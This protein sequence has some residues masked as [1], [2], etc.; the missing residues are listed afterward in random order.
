MELKDC[1]KADLLWV[2]DRATKCS[3]G[4]IG[5][6]IEQALCDLECKK[7]YDRIEKTKELLETSFKARQEYC[8]LLKPYEGEPILDVPLE[9][10]KKADSALKRSREADKKYCKLMGI[11]GFKH[12]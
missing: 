6:W 3:L 4:D 10:L 11:K 5:Y 1:T 12:T 9:V 8:D 2:I 7:E